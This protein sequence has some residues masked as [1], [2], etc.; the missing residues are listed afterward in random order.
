MKTGTT[1]GTLAKTTGFSVAAIRFYEAKGLLGPVDRTAN[2]R[3]SFGHIE[4]ASL[5]FIARCRDA[6]MSLDS[7]QQL[8]ALRDGTITP[9]DNVRQLV[10]QRIAEVREKIESMKAFVTN[11]E[12][13]SKQCL[14]GCCGA[15]PS[16][17]VVFQ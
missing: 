8:L 5:K 13:L 1:I 14:P 12:A 9:C 6:G 3:R 15:A 2:G 16:D 10:D 7:I 11:L 17:C 4:L